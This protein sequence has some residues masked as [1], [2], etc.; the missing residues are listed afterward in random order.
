MVN[1]TQTNKTSI[2]KITITPLAKRKMELYIAFAKG[3][4]S[5][6]GEVAYLPD[7]NEFRVSD[8][9]IFEQKTTGATTDL[10]EEAVA[11]FLVDTIQAGKD[12]SAF[13]VW[14]HSHANMSVFWSTTDTSTIEKFRNEWMISIVGNKS[15]ENLVRIDQYRPYRLSI[16]GLSLSLAEVAEE[17]DELAKAI[18]AE[19]EQKVQHS[20]M[21]T[22]VYKLGDAGNKDWTDAQSFWGYEGYASS[23]KKARDAN[24][25]EE[26]LG[27]DF[28]GSV[29]AFD[30]D[31][32]KEEEEEHTWDKE[33]PCPGCSYDDGNGTCSAGYRYVPEKDVCVPMGYD[34]GDDG[35]EVIGYYIEESGEV[36]AVMGD[37]EEV[38]EIRSQALGDGVLEDDGV[39]MLSDRQYQL[40]VENNYEVVPVE[41]DG[42]DDIR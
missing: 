24:E 13:R 31:D 30:S 22:N 39:L 15:G 26:T 38:E 19:V 9:M 2:P 32:E 27:L 11:K 8:V 17:E 29:V 35:L 28:D 1:Q 34:E 3:E 33:N 21:A 12:P 42:V 4:V 36:V 6:L 7:S 20:L 23:Y 5:G 40:Y 10:D 16:D 37:P 41:V 25:Q 14:W 18:R